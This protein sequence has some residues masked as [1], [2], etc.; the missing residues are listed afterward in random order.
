MENSDYHCDC[1]FCKHNHPFDI[2]E[3]LLDSFLEGE[4]VLFAGSGISTE[5]RNV[6]KYTFYDAIEGELGYE[7]R[8]GLSFPEL[9]EE[10][11]ERPNGR[12]KLL[13]AIRQRFNHIKS[14]PELYRTATRFHEE[15]STFYPLKT[16]ITTNWDTYFENKCNA[17]PFVTDQDLAFWEKEER[18][19]LKIHGSIN[20]YGSIVATQ[21]DYEDCEKRLHKEI[22]GS[23]LKSILA[24]KTIVFVGYS[25]SDSDFLNIYNFVSEQMK[26]MQR[27]AYVITP[28][29]EEKEHFEEL[30]LYPI[31]TDGTY[32]FEQL[33]R[34]TINEDLMYPDSIYDEADQLHSIVSAEHRHMFQEFNVYDHPQIIYPA[35][36]Q[37]GMMHAFERVTALKENGEYSRP[38]SIRGIFEPYKEWKQE[39]LSDERYEDVAYIDGYVRAFYFLITS[40][41]MKKKLEHPPLYYAFGVEENMV[42]SFDAFCEIVDDLP[43]LHKESYQ[44][45]V[46]LTDQLELESGIEFHHPPWL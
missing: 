46:E 1:S 21:S 15:V 16:I 18:K 32:F 23:I 31:I 29:E 10:Y 41:D 36:Y 19:V 17:T 12:I 6:L 39:K 27:Q 43:E 14:F 35:S 38:G 8:S 45:A 11:E 9:M 33:K 25:F 20:N 5:N 3:D 42:P 22:I 2:P 44:R 13:D 7:E 37:D 24:T 4:V 26:K 28:F 30:G 34:H 40:E